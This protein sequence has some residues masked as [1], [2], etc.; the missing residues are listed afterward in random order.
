MIRSSSA[1][2]HV[3]LFN[4]SRQ[5]L[6]RTFSSANVQL[7]KMDATLES[8][9]RAANG[10]VSERDL[11]RSKPFKKNSRQPDWPECSKE[12]VLITD[13]RKLLSNTKLDDG[14]AATPIELKT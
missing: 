10:E 2:S 8:R 12:D 6:N 4:F 1:V 13:I 5:V 3:A 9:K 14:K 7:R 11:K